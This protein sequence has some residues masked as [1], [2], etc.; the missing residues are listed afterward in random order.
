[1]KVQFVSILLCFTSISVGQQNIRNAQ[2][3][4]VQTFPIKSSPQLSQYSYEWSG[5]QSPPVANNQNSRSFSASQ[6]WSG[7][8]LNG[9]PDYKSSGPI[10]QIITITDYSKNGTQESQLTSRMSDPVDI[11]KLFQ[12]SYDNNWNKP[13]P[14]LEND[15]ASLFGAP[16]TQNKNVVRFGQN[17]PDGFG[18]VH[19][20]SPTFPNVAPPSPKTVPKK[21]SPSTFQYFSNAAQNKTLVPVG[22]KSKT[23]TFNFQ[24]FPSTEE[25]NTVW[26]NSLDGEVS[27][28][29]SEDTRSTSFRQTKKFVKAA[30]DSHN[31]YRKKHKASALSYNTQVAKVAQAWASKLIGSLA[32]GGRLQHRP[33]NKYGE[34][35]WMGSGYKFSD[36]E[37]V[38]FAVKAWYDEISIYKPY[39]G[40]EPNMANFM[41]WGHFTQVVWKSTSKL[42]MGIARKNGYIVVVANYDPPGNYKGNFAANV[43][44]P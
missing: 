5:V 44:K 3:Y 9:P 36:E 1:M 12:T 42:G 26:E 24:Q 16:P 17:I 34:N 22:V 8:Q 6:Q 25:L 43:K 23:R 37:A 33:N 13:S 20:P 32:R 30:L 38:R 29:K 35:L 7:Q 19:K 15:F 41:A 18:K 28:E 21:P 39:L 4:Y 2:P 27:A 11:F 10:Y 31:A 14:Q 40:R